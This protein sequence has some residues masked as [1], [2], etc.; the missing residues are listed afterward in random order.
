VSLLALNPVWPA[1]L[2]G[3]GLAAFPG[4]PRELRSG[5][6]N[7]L[8][9]LRNQRVERG[10]ALWNLSRG[11]TKSLASVDPVLAGGGS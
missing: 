9:E 7:S 10:V 8:D 1:Q 5:T 2:Q 3:R 11:P 4:T 6:R